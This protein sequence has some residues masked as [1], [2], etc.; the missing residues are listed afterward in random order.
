VGDN[1]FF[2]QGKILTSRTFVALVC[3]LYCRINIRGILF[4]ARFHPVDLSWGI[5][6]H[7]STGESL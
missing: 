6:D 2:D 4:N 3:F 7:Y 5:G 1:G